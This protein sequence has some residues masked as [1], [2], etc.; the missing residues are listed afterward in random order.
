MKRFTA[1]IEARARDYLHANGSQCRGPSGGTSSS[2]DRR[3]TTSFAAT[4]VCGV[5]PAGQDLGIPGATLAAPGD[6]QWALLVR[7]TRSTTSSRMPPLGSR[8]V[9]EASASVLE[10]FVRGLSASSP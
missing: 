5:A 1:P 7:R 3:A 6:S 9:E 8:K 10:G 2:P 4:K